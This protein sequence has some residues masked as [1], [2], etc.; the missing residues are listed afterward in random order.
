LLASGARLTFLSDNPAGAVLAETL[1]A[2][3]S[4]DV[5][6]YQ[7]VDQFLNLGYLPG[8][9]AAFASFAENPQKAVPVDFHSETA[10]SK[11]PLQGISALSDFNA[12]LILTDNGENVRA[13][14][15]Q[16]SGS[17]GD[18]S[19]LVISS[20]QSAPI[21]Q[22]YVQSGQV[23]GLVA[24]ISGAAAYDGLTQ[25]TDGTVRTY[26][27]AY[28]ATTLLIIAIILLGMVVQSIRKLS[29]PKKA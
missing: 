2:N 22:P 11:A 16:T 28:Q 12:V 13:W 7:P 15:E 20:A 1:V 26:W 29:A 18:T 4:A 3:A 17:L 21:V 9:V 27:D 8:G 10:W 23:S 5:G 19:L 6:A 14:I 24:G 25:R